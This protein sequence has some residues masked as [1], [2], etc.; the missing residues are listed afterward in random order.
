MKGGFNKPF[1]GAA[2]WWCNDFHEEQ[3]VCG[4]LAIGACNKQI[5]VVVPLLRLAAC[6]NIASG[7][8][9]TIALRISPHSPY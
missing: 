3:L 1:D 8:M 5:I 9:Q 4:V 7:D 2:R 6:M